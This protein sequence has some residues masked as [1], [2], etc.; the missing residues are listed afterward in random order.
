MRTGWRSMPSSRTVSD[1]SS[2]RAVPPPTRTASWLARSAWTWRRAIG[3]VIQRLS[4]VAVAI[5]PSASSAMTPL[6]RPPST[7]SR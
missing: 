5:R 7:V 3:P 6:E 2:A 4:P 1:G